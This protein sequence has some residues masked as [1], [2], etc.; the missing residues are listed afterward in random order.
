MHI[1]IAHLSL[2]DLFVAFFEVLPQ[3]IWDITFRFYGNDFTCKN[4]E[5]FSTGSYVRFVVRAGE[6]SH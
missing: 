2:A 3:L 5:I 4:S 6:H 1:L